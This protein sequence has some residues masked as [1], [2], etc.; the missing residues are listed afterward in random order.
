MLIAVFG[1]WSGTSFEAL[2]LNVGRSQAYWM[3]SPSCWWG[4]S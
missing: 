4:F 3:H 2:L 1:V